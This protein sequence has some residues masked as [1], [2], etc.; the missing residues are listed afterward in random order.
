MKDLGLVCALHV[1]ASPGC[2]DHF[3]HL[4]RDQKEVTDRLGTVLFH[5]QVT[6]EAANVREDSIPVVGAP[7][8][9]S[10]QGGG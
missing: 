8:K 2:D 4:K 6:V 5:C 10:G 9:G 7:C 1:L 3:S